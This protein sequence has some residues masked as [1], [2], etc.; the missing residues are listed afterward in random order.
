M[1]DADAT[2]CP[3]CRQEEL[4][5][6]FL[7]E[8][9]NVLLL[10]APEPLVDGHLLLAARAHLPCMAALPPE[11]EPELARLKARAVALL[12]HTASTPAVFESADCGDPAAH[13]CW[14]LL[15]GASGLERE[16]S[17]RAACPAE[18]LAALRQVAR[19]CRRYVYW[20]AGGARLAVPDPGGEGPALLAR[21]AG[22]VRAE[23]PLMPGREAARWLRGVWQGRM[24][25]AGEAIQVVTCVLRRGERLCLLRRSPLLDSAPGK[26][27]GISGY[28]PDG[29]DPLQH[30]LREIEQEVGLDRSRV[31]LARAGAPVTFGSPAMG[32]IWRIHPFLFD[33][34]EGEP[35]LN[36]EHTELVWVLP[37]EV[38]QY[39]TVASLPYLVQVLMGGEDAA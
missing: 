28:L 24:A 21:L 15:P 30:A 39:D 5:P 14:H 19:E 12:E 33:V 8:A 36:W 1:L 34:L 17:A 13:A 27:H 11:A 35:R 29:V 9:A 16:L 4:E 32:R 22:S 3:L 6:L 31:A 2:H 25:A 20:E 10:V 7:S 26:W 23:G 18:E 37:G 38:E